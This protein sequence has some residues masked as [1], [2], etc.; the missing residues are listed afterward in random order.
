MR[1]YSHFCGSR[2]G[3]ISNGWNWAVMLLC[4]G[5]WDARAQSAGNTPQIV[6][7]PQSQ[8]ANQGANVQLSVLATGSTPL[9]YQWLMNDDE[10]PGMTSSFLTISNAQYWNSG[11]YA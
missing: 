1:G 5:V 11:S 6:T 3:L 8:I 10:L 4:L 2:R 7:N 9:F